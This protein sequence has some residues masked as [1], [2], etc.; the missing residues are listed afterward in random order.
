MT[1]TGVQQTTDVDEKPT[2]NALFGP[3]GRLSTLLAKNWMVVVLVV[4]IVV[5]SIIAPGFLSQSNFVSTTLAAST[6]LILGAAE[7][8]VILTAGIDLSVGAILGFS[9]MTTA[10]TMQAFM[11]GGQ[12]TTVVIAAGV[13]AGLLTG[14]VFGA[15]NGFVITRMNITPFIATLGTLGIA[16]GFTFLITNG[17]EIIN[18]PQSIGNFGNGSLFGWLPWPFVVAILVA[19]ISA[20]FLRKTKFG[21]YTYAV[22]SNP[23]GSRVSGINLKRHLFF[24]YTL[25]GVLSGLAGVLVVTRLVAGSPLE[26]AND[27]LNA[28]AAVVIGGA[29]LF[30]GVG[31]MPGTFVGGLVISIL[32]TGLVIAGV[33]PYW[34]TV[35]V[36]IAIILAVFVDQQQQAKEN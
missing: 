35:A 5:F 12:S 20:Y 29:S 32:V 15:V 10:Y 27:E 2:G 4:L 28:I 24:I 1:S 22:G 11:T 13:V 19:V 8:F 3:G 33:Q 30:G 36:G 31:T 34:Q 25:S 21:L 7:T 14:L 17:T 9:G 6:T 23:E 16:T 18:V 26:G